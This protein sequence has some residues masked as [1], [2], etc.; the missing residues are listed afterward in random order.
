MA[1]Q[2]KPLG[3]Q[4]LDSISNTLTSFNITGTTMGFPKKTLTREDNC[5]SKKVLSLISDGFLDMKKK[6]DKV[7]FPIHQTNEIKYKFYFKGYHSRSKK[8][9]SF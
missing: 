4:T 1:L 8:K 7:F 5:S 6:L 9:Y 2:R 3:E